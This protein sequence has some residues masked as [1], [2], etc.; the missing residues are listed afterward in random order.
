MVVTSTKG[1]TVSNG[2]TTDERIQLF[3]SLTICVKEAVLISLIKYSKVRSVGSG[4]SGSN[5]EL[6][7]TENR[8]VGAEVGR[9]E[10]DGAEVGTLVGVDEG[11]DVG[12]ELDGIPV[13]ALDG[14]FVSPSLVG[15]TVGCGD[16][17][18]VGS[19][20]GRG[21]GAAVGFS[22]GVLVGLN[23]GASVGALVGANVGFVLGF[24]VGT[25]EGAGVG[26]SLG[27]GDG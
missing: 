22:V 18:G 1:Y 20:E 8:V 5:D 17:R 21:E 4:M 23:D 12:L 16:G 14:G 25:A 9:N 27:A 26:L 7:K 13:G 11:A 3:Q 24:G 2:V 19:G 15:L 10:I 6:S